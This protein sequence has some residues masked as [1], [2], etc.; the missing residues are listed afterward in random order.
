[1]RKT[2][3]FFTTLAILLCPLLCG[4]HAQAA[5][6]DVVIADYAMAEADYAEVLSYYQKLPAGCRRALETYGWTI[7][8]AGG[9]WRPTGGQSASRT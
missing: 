8:A 5:A 1:M 7:Q 2:A 9:H 4:E 6:T 3:R